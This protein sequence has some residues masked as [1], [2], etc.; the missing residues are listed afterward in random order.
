MN[1][2]QLF[3]C[4]IRRLYYSQ[5]T[6]SG[7]ENVATEGPVL[8]LCL[9]RNGAV[10]GFVYLAAMPRLKF[11]IRAKLRSGLVG[12]LFF[13]GLDVTRSDDGGRTEDILKMIH[14]CGSALRSGSSL[15]IF[16]EGTSQ[17]GPRHLPFQSGAARIAL[18]CLEAEGPLTILPLGIH[19]ECPWAF[20]SRVEVVVDAPISLPSSTSDLSKGLRL[21]E[22]KQRFTASLEE[23]GINVPDEDTQDL[24]QKFAYIATLGT[25]HCYFSAL[26]AMETR[27]PSD[28]VSGWKAFE[29]R[30]EGKW[31]LK[32]QGVPLF[33]LRMTWVY[34]ILTLF[35]GVP[36]LVGAMLNAPPV[37]T[38]W[39]AGVRFADDNNVIA[40]WRILTGVPL[41]VLWAAAWIVCSI[42]LGY[43]WTIPIYLLLTSVA[44]FGWY[45]LKKVAVASW[46]GLF[47][48]RMGEQA[49][50]VHRLILSHLEGEQEIDPSPI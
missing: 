13:P 23:V 26:K 42:A 50:D 47:H 48:S 8:T 7:S 6:V 5:I 25:D 28:A 17:L 22:I 24:L 35:L 32:H 12:K 10:D 39:I 27:L 44:V 34:P 21:R 3:H 18:N 40:L 9:H 29:A 38:A 2:H 11:L 14:D 41:F 49:H 43:T 16:P 31:I 45:R 37:V 15:A 19:Y 36:V 1:F 46:N 20:R 33:P 30:A 4:F